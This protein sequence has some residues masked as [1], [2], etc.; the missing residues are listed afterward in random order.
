MPNHR[1]GVDLTKDERAAYAD[2]TQKLSTDV[3]KGERADALRFAIN[4][5][6]HVN[7]L[8]KHINRLAQHFYRDINTGLPIDRNKGELIALMHSELSEMLE[9]VRKNT[10]DSHLPTRRSEEVELADLIIRALDYAAWRGLDLQGAI[11][12]KLQ[13]NA[14]RKDHTDEARRAKNGKKF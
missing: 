14:T 5:C 9:G 4:C 8:A 1:M 12:D 7:L 13:Y 10:F 3:D 2:M 11:A 6:E